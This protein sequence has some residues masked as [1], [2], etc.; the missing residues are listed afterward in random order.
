MNDKEGIASSLSPIERKILPFLECKNVEEIVEKAKT[1]KTTVLRALEF[2]SNKKI[3]ELSCKKQKNVVLGSNGVLYTKD[4]LP[5]R[6]LLN[7]FSE[8]TSFSLEEAG[9]E[10][11]LS[12]NEFKAALGALKKKA[13]VN[14]ENGRIALQGTKENVSRKMPEEVFLE[15]LPIEV[16][17]LTAEQK[18]CHEHLKNRRDIVRI[19]EQKAI[20][21]QLTALGKSIAKEPLNSTFVEQL[22]PEMLQKGTWKG[23]KFRRYDII[24]RVP[25]IYG[26]RRQPCYE[27]LQNVREKL[28][29]M[30]FE[31]MNGSIIENEFWNYDALFQP[32]FHA[33]R[34]WSSTYYIKNKLK[35]EQIDKKILA[36]VKQQHEASWQYSWKIENALKYI[37]RPQGTV[38][39]ARQLAKARIPGK[40]FA[41]ARCYRPDVV[42]ASHLSEFNQAEGI[43]VQENL[44]LRNLF[45]ILELFAGEIANAKEIKFVPH[46]FPFTEPSVEL[47]AKHPKF[48]WIELGG[49][50]IF[51]REVVKPLLGKDITVLAWGLG[52][53]RLAMFNLNINDIRQLFSQDIDWLRGVK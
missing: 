2:L 37:L 17:S 30:G 10:S 52:I 26:G 34:E 38:L 18:Y 24:S 14:V 42:D 48:G 40:Y 19:E 43:I 11:S 47:H 20:S 9:K 35:P 50:G 32:Q 22:T 23:K 8:E 36:R 51:R 5:E 6:K 31:E 21:F 39:S 28:V 4:G 13:L 3:V 44:T 46:Y 16:E 41:I 33:A 29:A 7:I 49:A 12:E 15:Q 25:R 45:Y 53:D 27:F 1:D